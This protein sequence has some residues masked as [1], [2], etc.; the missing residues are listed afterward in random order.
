MKSKISILK[1]VKKFEWRKLREIKYMGFQYR[2]FGVDFDQPPSEYWL[3]LFRFRV[4]TI[5]LIQIE[6]S[7]Y[8]VHMLSLKHYENFC[9]CWEIQTKS[10][11]N[12]ILPPKFWK[13]SKVSAKYRQHPNLVS[14]FAINVFYWIGTNNE[15]KQT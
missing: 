15:W 1:R 14:I 10:T 6:C 2:I 7:I 8:C 12:D 11:E 3:Q 13:L 4:W 9:C 5:H